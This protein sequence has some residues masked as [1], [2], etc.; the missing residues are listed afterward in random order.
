LARL[1][2]FLAGAPDS[3]VRR[4]TPATADVDSVIDVR[5]VLQQDHR[6]LALEGM[7][8]FLLPRK[9]RY[10]LVDYEKMFCPDLK[11]GGDIF[12]MR[13]IDRDQGCIVVV[14][15]DQHIAHI[16]PI[17]AHAEL[18][19]FFAGFMRTRTDGTA[20]SGEPENPK[21]AG[22]TPASTRVS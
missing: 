8:P 15:P 16:L 3:P 4:F 21:D 12:D 19:G 5:A 2:D 20:D 9:G 10:G 6:T 22:P 11:S 14:R 17:D 1:C 7:P 13:G 18:V